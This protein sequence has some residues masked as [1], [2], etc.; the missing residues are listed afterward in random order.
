MNDIDKLRQDILNS[1]TFCFYPFLEMSTNPAGHVKPCCYFTS[2]LFENPDVGNFESKTLSILNGSNN[3]E[4]I[5]NSRA[6]VS[7]RKK[8][9]EGQP[10]KH[11]RTCTRD[12]KASMR[13]RSINEY[14]NNYQVLK[15]VSKTA[16]NDYIANHLPKR[17]ELKPSNLCNLK[18]VMCNSYDSSQVAKELKELTTKF[19]GI[20]VVSGR[21]SKISDTPGMT[22]TSAAFTEVDQPDWSTDKD[23]WNSIIKIIPHLEVLSF[24]GGEPTLIPLVEDILRFCVENDYAKNIK[25]FC[26]S[27]FTNINK[28]FLD[29]MP[30]FKQFELIASI[31]GIEKINDYCRFPSKWSQVSTNYLKAKS[32]MGDHP[33]V[34]I[35]I[36]ITVSL[37]NVL[38]LDSLLNWIED[39]AKC[40]PYYYE[41]PY[42]INL[43]WAPQDQSIGNLPQ[44]LK[45]LAI[46]RLNSYKQTSSILKEFPELNSKIDLVID[47]LSHPTGNSETDLFE[48]FIL[49]VSVLNEHR[50]IK[51]KD[52]IPDLEEF[53][54][55][56]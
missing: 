33:N 6:M 28:K 37:L 36:N 38:N 45:D 49:R 8:L 56:E 21:Y 50:G 7:I 55:H 22:E 53:F 17:L 32:M 13:T 23:A 14:K 11:C 44:H 19:K 15:L 52:Y 24:A 12:G 4:D 25:V 5:W 40:Y 10:E 39:L 20:E 31:D 34:K 35:L 9:F 16:K 54:N 47:E 43:I 3:L 46:S 48:E 2:V 42:N 1:E 51:M 27:N 29:L 30:H 41:W 18:C 26:S